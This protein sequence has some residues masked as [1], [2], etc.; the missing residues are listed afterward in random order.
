MFPDV[1]E[2]FRSPFFIQY[3]CSKMEDGIQL[4]PKMKI[5][6]GGFDPFEKY[7]RQ[8]GSFPQVGLKI[9]TI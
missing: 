5:L 4:P 8:I 3:I 1:H 7:A 6:A 9:K 2:I